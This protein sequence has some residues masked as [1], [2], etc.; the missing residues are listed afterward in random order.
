MSGIMKGCII[1][2]KRLYEILIRRTNDL[3]Y[4]VII[5]EDVIN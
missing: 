5:R 2:Y 3:N 1:I 4:Y